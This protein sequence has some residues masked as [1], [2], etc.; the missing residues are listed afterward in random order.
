MTSTIRMLQSD[1]FLL[2]SQKPGK[3]VFFFLPRPLSSCACASPESFSHE[4]GMND[5]EKSRGG[6]C[7]WLHLFVDVAGQQQSVQG[8]DSTAEGRILYARCLAPFFP[9]VMTVPA[10]DRKFVNGNS[11]ANLTA[12][13]STFTSTSQNAFPYPKQ[14]LLLLL[15]FHTPA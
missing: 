7:T 15:L 12:S 1:R 2:V 5:D 3:T 13:L 6:A 4:I 11:T 14:L 10:L 9:V 8:R